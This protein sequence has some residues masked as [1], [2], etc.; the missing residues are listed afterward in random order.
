MQGASVERYD[1]ARRNGLVERLAMAQSHR[2]GTRILASQPALERTR[3]QLYSAI[4]SR[5]HR[6]C[7]PSFSGGALNT[8]HNTV[9]PP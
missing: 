3:I 9:F 5:V 8:L 7:G 6:I 2:S 1:Y 4:F